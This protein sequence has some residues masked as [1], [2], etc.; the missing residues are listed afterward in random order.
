M[1]PPRIQSQ[2]IYLDSQYA[3]AT[4]NTSKRN[5]CYFF[6]AVP[7]IVPQDYDIVLR[8]DNFTCPISFFAVNDTNNT[9]VTS[10]GTYTLTEGNYNALTLRAELQ[11]QM[12]GYTVSYDASTNK[13][14][15]SYS[16]PFTFMSTSTCFR[17]LG[18]EE[19]VDHVSS[20]NALVS[21]FVVNLAGTSLLYI[22]I[23]NITTKNILAKNNG[24]FTTIVKS[25]VC[26]APYG[27]ILTY[28][29]NTGASVRLGEKYIS[30]LQVRILDDDYNL[31]DLNGQYFSLTI[32]MS[33]DHNGA[34]V[35]TETGNLLDAI[36][37]QNQVRE[38]LSVLKETQS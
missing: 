23:P 26:D 28:T 19:D 20:S 7:I 22:D 32:E 9:L 27:S 36:K 6:F 18:F 38:S 16:S 15:I 12:I 33:Y 14:R 25:I 17:I 31:L 5:D 29:N 34:P 2:E 37:Q 24:G 35:S 4:V 30:Y 8:I 1:N 13:M 21:D 10:T 3:S 11:S